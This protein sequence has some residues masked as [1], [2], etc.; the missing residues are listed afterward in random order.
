M[1]IFFKDAENPTGDDYDALD[2]FFLETEL[3]PNMKKTDSS[4]AVWQNEM[5]FYTQKTQEA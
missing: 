2:D 1:G 3:D 4:K 5:G